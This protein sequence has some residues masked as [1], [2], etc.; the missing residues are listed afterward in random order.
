MK[1]FKNN[2]LIR[3]KMPFFYLIFAI[4]FTATSCN[5]NRPPDY[6]ANVYEKYFETNILN[7]D[8]KVKL[9]MDNGVDKTPEFV[10]F[11]FKLLKNTYHDGPMTG[12]RVSNPAIIY[13]GTWSSNEDYS[14][15]IISITQP[16]IPTEFIYLNR[17]WRF[18][19]KAI[20]VMELEPW[21]GEP[22]ILHMERL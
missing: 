2:L 7:S 11:K 14:N 21:N 22:K 8:Y 19:K 20:P 10:D 5:K 4:L 18:T 6:I 1:L 3:A 13:T 17:T 16:T 15:L 12:T 9:A